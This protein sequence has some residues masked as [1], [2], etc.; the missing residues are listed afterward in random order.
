MGIHIMP[1]LYKMVIPPPIIEPFYPEP[2]PE[3]TT[4]DGSVSQKYGGPGLG[5]VWATIIAASGNLPEGH[6]SSIYAPNI[7]ADVV[8]NLWII[9]ARGIFLFNTSSLPDNC[10]IV[11]AVFSLYGWYKVDTFTVPIAPDVNV[12]SSNPAS[13]TH[14]VGEDY[15]TLGSTPFCDTP[16]TFARWSTTGYN[17]F[18]LNAAG[19]AAIS[20]TGIT[21]LGTRN[22]NYDVAGV[23]PNWESDKAAQ[24]ISWAAEKGDEYKPKLV[25]TYRL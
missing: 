7:G 21:K 8:A 13:D 1:P 14:L 9:N 25:I 12:Y 23:A 17:D 11:K 10:S 5:G 20:K 2:H 4:V 19:R 22:A 18:V 24:L 16:I 6:L 3:I 15:A